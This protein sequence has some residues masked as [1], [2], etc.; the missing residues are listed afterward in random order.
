MSKKHHHPAGPCL[1]CSTPLQEGWEFC[2]TCGQKNED[3]KLPFSH[4]LEELAEGIWHFDSKLWATLKAVVTRPGKITAD[5]LDG[6]RV[7]YVPPI[8]LYV[9]I[10]F[11]FFFAASVMQHRG[12]EAEAEAALMHPKSRKGNGDFTLHIGPSL[13]ADT[14]EEVLQS[15]RKEAV[16]DTVALLIAGSMDEGVVVSAARAQSLKGLRAIEVQKRLTDTMLAAYEQRNRLLPDSDRAYIRDGSMAKNDTVLF[17]PLKTGERLAIRLPVFNRN[18]VLDSANID[19]LLHRTKA[20]RERLLDR[21]R[22]EGRI[23]RIGATRAARLVELGRNGN[24]PSEWAE[25]WHLMFKAASIGMFL[26]MPLA[27]FFLW[28][29][30]RHQRR[31]YVEHLIHAL[32]LHA[33]IFLLIILLEFLPGILFPHHQFGL[34]NWALG[35]LILIYPFLSIRRVYRQRLR[36]TLLKYL[37]WIILYGVLM[38][39]FVV[40]VFTYGLITV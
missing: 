11:V 21:Y 19:T 6:R 1:N 10:S 5:F 24:N 14:T 31:F 8:R 29:L 36:R 32:H 22:V 38:L 4:V 27:A 26:F 17:R 37:F 35:I 33:I 25:L 2:P 3:L 7:R 23:R 15:L 9:F 28:L 34:L 18:L 40:G 13:D 16:L 30:F 12:E 39:L 20:E